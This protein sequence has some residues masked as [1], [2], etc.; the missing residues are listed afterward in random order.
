VREGDDVGQGRRR[1]IKERMEERL[2][3][4]GMKERDEG[5][6]REGVCL[7]T[8]KAWGAMC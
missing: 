6:G 4:A 2:R 8:C 7:E 3:R 5:E 1:R